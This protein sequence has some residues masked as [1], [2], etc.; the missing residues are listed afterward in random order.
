M[1]GSI[2]NQQGT[3]QT[4]GYVLWPMQLTS[5]ISTD[6]EQCILRNAL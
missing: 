3:I 4:K 1:E 6:D 2:P 5:N